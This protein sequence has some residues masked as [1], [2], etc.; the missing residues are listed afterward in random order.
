MILVRLTCE[1][2]Q[3]ISA[4]SFRSLGQSK[5]LRNSRNLI[6]HTNAHFSA[7]PQW[8]L[9]TLV[10][11][12]LLSLVPVALTS[13]T[14]SLRVIRKTHPS[15]PLEYTTSSRWNLSTLCLT[16]PLIRERRSSLPERWSTSTILQSRTVRVLK[17]SNG[18]SRGLCRRR[19]GPKMWTSVTMAVS[20]Q[21]SR[22]LLT[23]PVVGRQSV[24]SSRKHWVM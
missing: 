4:Q 18:F 9:P 20:W 5:R 19:K 17:N 24:C 13:L 11:Q 21:M 14:L 7:M 23:W 3:T 22:Q 8:K 12:P 16:T 10:F 6:V 15:S 1:F 2:L